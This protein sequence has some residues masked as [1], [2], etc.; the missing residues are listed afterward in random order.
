M[1]E[2]KKQLEKQIERLQTQIALAE[3]ELEQKRQNLYQMQGG[4]EATIGLLNV[5]NEL[6]AE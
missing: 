5:Y 2:Y 4:L 6:N 1:E 3:R